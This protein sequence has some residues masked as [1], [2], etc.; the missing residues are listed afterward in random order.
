MAWLG[1]PV[2]SDAV[3]PSPSSPQNASPATS[4][5]KSPTAAES[6]RL[7][8]NC[9]SR[10][11]VRPRSAS[12]G[13][14]PG[15]R[16]NR[17]QAVPRPALRGATCQARHYRASPPPASPEGVGRDSQS[18]APTGACPHQAS[19]GAPKENTWTFLYLVKSRPASTPALK[20]ELTSGSDLRPGPNRPPDL[21][22][23]PHSQG[24][25]PAHPQPP[26]PTRPRLADLLAKPWSSSD[27]RP[28]R[29][30]PGSGA[31]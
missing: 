24:Q 5:G 11:R 3:W 8:D 9:R 12:S 20:R 29:I 23:R 22:A 26:A 1:S 4:A 25:V 18:H 31:A 6:L 10:A 17:G 21:P 19:V 27:P 2:S 14:A 15:S 28:R 30:W 16:H 7:V 13:L